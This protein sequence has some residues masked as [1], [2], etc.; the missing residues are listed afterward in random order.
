MREAFWFRQVWAGRLTEFQ[1]FNI[2]LR[3]GGSFS[4]LFARARTTPPQT[5][6]GPSDAYRLLVYATFVVDV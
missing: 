2:L 6:T 1:A 4:P 3:L 5:A